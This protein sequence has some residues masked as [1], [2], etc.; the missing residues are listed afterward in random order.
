MK[1]RKRILA[2][3]TAGLLMLALCPMPAQAKSNT[4]TLAQAKKGVVQIYFW[5]CNSRYYG[6]W[7]G[8][9][10]A[11]GTAG[12]ESNIFVTNWHVVTQDDIPI[13][14]EEHIW[15]LQEGCTID[16]NG[17]P[18]PAKSISC[19]LLKTTSGYPDYAIL[20]ATEPVSGYEPLPL[21]PSDQ[22]PDG[23]NVY[24]LGYPGDIS[25][26]S[27]SHYGIDDITVTNG[28]VSQHMELNFAGNT[29]ALLHTAQ[30]AHGNS[31]GPLI[32]EGGAVVGLNTYGTSEDGER[33]YAVDICYV[34]DALDSLN[35]SYDLYEDTGEESSETAAKAAETTDSS[36]VIIAAASIAVVVCLGVGAYVIAKTKEKNKPVPQPVYTPPAPSAPPRTPGTPSGSGTSSASGTPYQMPRVSSPPPAA[37]EP[38]YTPPPVSP[39]PQ[40]QKICLRT[41]N[42]KTFTVTGSATFGRDPQCKV[43]LPEDA[44]GVSRVHCRVD[45]KGNALMLMDLGSS[46]GT[47]VGGKKIV[48]NAP[49]TL[50]IGDSFSLGSEKYIFTYCGL[51]Q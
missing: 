5:A 24:A 25:A 27:T 44:K 17:K 11:V 46:Y 39:A 4:D 48:P 33:Y 42:G 40:K 49:V 32:T 21:I 30:I 47:F 43:S 37:P 19:E 8:S 45:L 13:P 16:S 29:K 22:V 26:V 15:I 18:D 20:R 35:I 38:A 1:L 31:G 36:T 12:K 51:Q 9:G 50:K 34:M 28:I 41:A 14:M 10:F 2:L 23:S 3:L 6:A 7:S